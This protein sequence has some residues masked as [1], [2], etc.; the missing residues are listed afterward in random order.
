MAQTIVRQAQEFDCRTF[1]TKTTK[2]A[3][4]SG[5]EPSWP[6][7]RMLPGLLVLV[8]LIVPGGISC[9]QAKQ[10]QE[11]QQTAAQTQSSERNPGGQVINQVD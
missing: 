7:V 2:K 5:R 10:L 8:V 6:K 11:Q 9:I 3:S 4:T 1:G